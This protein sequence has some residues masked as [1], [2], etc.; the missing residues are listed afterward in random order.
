MSTACIR[1]GK[2]DNHQSPERGQ[3][4]QPFSYHIRLNLAVEIGEYHIYA[5]SMRNG[6]SLGGSLGRLVKER[7][8]PHLTNDAPARLALHQ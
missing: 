3:Q 5:I 1:V 2:A 4:A 8:G 7:S 6:W